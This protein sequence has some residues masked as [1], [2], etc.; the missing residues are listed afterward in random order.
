MQRIYRS[1]MEQVKNAKYLKTTH[2]TNLKHDDL[3]Q[4]LELPHTT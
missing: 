1:F 2:L 4:A 3:L